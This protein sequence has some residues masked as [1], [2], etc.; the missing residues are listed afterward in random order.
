MSTFTYFLE[1]ALFH[2]NEHCWYYSCEMSDQ[3]NEARLCTLKRSQRQKAWAVQENV[4][5][6]RQHIVMSD[7]IS[8]CTELSIFVIDDVQPTIP[9]TLKTYK[10]G[11]FNKTSFFISILYKSLFVNA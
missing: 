4:F 1:L 7:M 5:I 9:T 8:F 2:N 6:S 3:K 10:N 11:L